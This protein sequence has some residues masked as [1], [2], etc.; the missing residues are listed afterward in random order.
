MREKLVKTGAGA[1]AP[2]IDALETMQY[3]QTTLMTQKGQLKD[4][5][6]NIAV[7]LQERDKA[8]KTFISDNGQ[9]YA[10]AA[11][12][13]DDY[14]QRLAKARVKRE[15]MTLVSPVAG[16]IMSLSVTTLGQVVTTSEELMRIVPD[17]SVLEI[18]CYLENKDIGFVAVGQEAQVKME[19]LPLHALW[20]DQSDRYE[21]RARCDPGTGRAIDRRRSGKDNQVGPACRRTTHAK[22]GLSGHSF[23]RQTVHQGGRS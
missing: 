12:Q 16:T 4:A 3:H 6:A 23:N 22:S 17:D 2:V 1:R 7:L 8:F 11:R 5:E 20:L 10:E 19:F 21:C 15:H 18:E 13:R 14:E 9:K